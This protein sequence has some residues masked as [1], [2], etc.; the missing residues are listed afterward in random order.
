MVNAK[1]VQVQSFLQRTLPFSIFFFCYRYAISECL[2]MAHKTVISWLPAAGSQSSM[3]PVI[4]TVSLSDEHMTL[5]TNVWLWKLPVLHGFN[6]KQTASPWSLQHSSV[7]LC[8]LFL[9]LGF[10]QLLNKRYT[11]YEPD[12]GFL[13]MRDSHA[14]VENFF[15]PHLFLTLLF[16]SCSPMPAGGTESSLVP[17]RPTACDWG[18]HGDVQWNVLQAEEGNYSSIS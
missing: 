3:S 9:G 1:N 7:L 16:L 18:L 10:T 4:F 15:F 2:A 13:L 8:A 14:E 6:P 5:L 17:L 11:G 12:P